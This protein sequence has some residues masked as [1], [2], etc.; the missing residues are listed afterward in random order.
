M[1]RGDSPVQ[2]PVAVFAS[3]SGTNFQS[4]LDREAEGA[5]YRIELLVTDRA[6][7]AE[8]RARAAGKAVR[9]VGFNDSGASGDPTAQ[10]LAALEGAGAQAILLAGFVQL[11]PA[12]VCQAYR[13][14]ALNVHPALL[15]SFGGKGMYGARVHEAVLRAGAKLSGPTVHY[16]NE[17]YDDGEIVAQWPV[18][19]LP[20]DTPAA[21][22]ARVLEVEHALYPEAADVLARG[23]VSGSAPLFRWP[24]RGLGAASGAGPAV[25]KAF[26]ANR[27]PDDDD[28]RRLVAEAFGGGVG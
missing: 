10:V 4:L 25:G 14:R 28:L 3:G 11:L 2:V 23:I 27:R 26:P 5:A 12:P 15:P 19:V 1:T 16:V 18:P 20:G 17:R 22:A 13:G 24:G 6:C 21:L 7:A 8:G 9:R